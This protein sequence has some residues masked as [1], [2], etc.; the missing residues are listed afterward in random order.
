M[1]QKL[2]ILSQAAE[3]KD[4]DSGI[5]LG[6]EESE[7]GIVEV[8]AHSGDRLSVAKLVKGRM[9]QKGDLCRLV[10]SSPRTGRKIFRVV[11]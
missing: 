5:V 6:R 10:D 7:L 11:V 8:A 1:G 3:I 4:P 2:K 9:P